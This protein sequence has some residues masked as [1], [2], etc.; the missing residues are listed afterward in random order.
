MFRNSKRTSAAELEPQ[1]LNAVQGGK[2]VIDPY[3]GRL[4]QPKLP[5]GIWRHIWDALS[6]VAHY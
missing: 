6:A 3:K 1:L 2:I 5:T 4:V